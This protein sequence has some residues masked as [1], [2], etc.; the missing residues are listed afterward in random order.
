MVG[1]LHAQNCAGL[2][3]M[4]ILNIAKQ[5][6]TD[7]LEHVVLKTNTIAAKPGFKFVQL[8]DTE[9]FILVPEEYQVRFIDFQELLSNTIGIDFVLDGSKMTGKITCLPRSIG[10][11][12]CKHQRISKTEIGCPACMAVKWISASALSNKSII[13]PPYKPA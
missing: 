5:M 11:G 8:R 7:Q 3:N 12:E 9:I 13:I 6:D 10:I 1:L 2:H 4:D